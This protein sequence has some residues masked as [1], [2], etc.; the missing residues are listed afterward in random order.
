[1]IRTTKEYKVEIKEPKR[2]ATLDE[3]PE[4]NTDTNRE[5]K[6]CCTLSKFSFRHGSHLSQF[7]WQGMVPPT[8]AVLVD[9]IRGWQVRMAS[10][11]RLES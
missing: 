9:K 3:T 11:T 7:I 6:L 5:R 10:S 2:F 8:R 1:M 4:E